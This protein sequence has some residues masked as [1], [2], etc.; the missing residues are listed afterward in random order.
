M[1]DS[2]SALI[3]ANIFKNVFSL[4]CYDVYGMVTVGNNKCYIAFDITNGHVFKNMSNRF[5]INNTDMSYGNT[6]QYY[7][8]NINFI[9]SINMDISV[10]EIELRYRDTPIAKFLSNIEN[11]EYYR[12]T[13]FNVLPLAICA[14]SNHTIVCGC[15][16]SKCNDSSKS[17]SRNYYHW[18]YRLNKDFI[19]F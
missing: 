4:E 18:L 10:E 5:V 6:Y 15:Q 2:I 8:D 13:K 1:I 7:I 3:I 17:K 16:F 9:N 11:P 12:L 14:E 19:K